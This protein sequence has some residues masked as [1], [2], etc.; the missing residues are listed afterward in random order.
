MT[1]LAEG[2][3]AAVRIG[4]E[5]ILIANV[6]GQYHAISNRCSHAGRPLSTG[7]LRG[8]ELTC[9][10]HGA[11]FDVRTGAVLGAPAETGLKRF[12]VLIEAGR[13]NLIV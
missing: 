9:P 4:G 10:A 2:E 1:A 6:H 8:H 13:V 7:T 12:P 5:E 11:T 3:M